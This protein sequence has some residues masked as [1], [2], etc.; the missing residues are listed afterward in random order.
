MEYVSHGPCLEK[1]RLDQTE[2]GVGMKDQLVLL[3]GATGFIG[4]R[5][6]RRFHEQGIRVRCLVRS[7]KKFQTLYPNLSDIE[8]AEG[9][10]VQGT[11]L[12]EAL[13]GVQASY[14]LVHSMGPSPGSA[15]KGFAEKDRLAA[16][17]FRRAA[18]EAGV[19]RIIYLSGLGE[20]GSG[21]STHLS[22]RQEVGQILASGT[23]AATE[24]RAGVI[25]GSGGASFEIIRYLTERLPVMVAPRWVDTR[26]Q[27][28]YVENVLDYL[29]GCLEVPETAGQIFEIC[30]PDQF[31][32]RELML[33][34][35]RVRGLTR[36]ILTVPVLTPKLSSYWVQLVTP[37]P[38]SLVQPLIGGLKSE[39]I[40]LDTRI[41][42]LI[43]VRLIPMEEAICTA[44]SEEEQGPGAL[45]SRQACLF[46]E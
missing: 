23:V 18:E 33:T 25:I 20:Q 39:V 21:L 42:D 34:Y 19:E 24:L 4:G 30:G 7:P 22:S 43:P 44:L 46:R 15:G 29:A 11:G 40:C 17:N 27:P 31:S 8:L 1:Q 9:D 10:L 26:C 3:T 2:K 12:A 41:H 45:P 38:G 16:R 32:Y 35:A 37:I 13:Q 5:L 36:F 6:L 14:Y 28:I